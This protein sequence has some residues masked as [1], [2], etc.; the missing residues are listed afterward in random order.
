[1]KS[2]LTIP[3]LSNGNIRRAADILAAEVY[4]FYEPVY[5]KR[6]CTK[7]TTKIELKRTYQQTLYMKSVLTIPVLSNGN[8]RRAADILAAEV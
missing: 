7:I 6:N 4:F 1:M 8:V 3:V 2:V 5:K